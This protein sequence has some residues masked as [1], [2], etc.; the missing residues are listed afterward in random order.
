MAAERRTH[1]F[2]KG[3]LTGLVLAG[4]ALLGLAWLNPPRPLLPPEVDPGTLEAPAAPGQPQGA[5]EPAAP[6]SQ[7]LLPSAPAKPLIADAPVP[8]AAPAAAG[9]PSLMPK[10]TP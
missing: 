4:A 9:S 3:F 1:G 7:A 6:G 8:D 5:A 10:A 2:W